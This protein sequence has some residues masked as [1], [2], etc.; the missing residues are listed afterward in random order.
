[1]LCYP[2]KL[3]NKGGIP[4][5]ISVLVGEKNFF[6]RRSEKRNEF[7]LDQFAKRITLEY[8]LKLLKERENRDKTG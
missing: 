4:Y 1:M 6:N 7:I 2:V 3:L 8:G 5:V